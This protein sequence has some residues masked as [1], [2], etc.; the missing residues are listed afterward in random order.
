MA[1]FANPLLPRNGHTFVVG[2][3][4]R[5]SGC[6]NQKE[7]SLDDQ[8]DHGKQVAAE[9]DYGPAEYR[10][11]ATKGK[12]ERLDRPELAEIEALLRSG[13]LDLLV[14]EDIGRLV[15]GT[16]AARLCGLAVDHGTRVIAPNDCIDTAEDSWEEDVI[17]ACRDHVGHN[18]HTSKRLKHKLMNRFVKSGA[19]TPREIYGYIKPPGAKTY[20]D[21]QKD[22]AAT[23]IYQEWFERLRRLPNCS[24]VA[25]W[26]NAQQVPTGKYCRRK[27]WDGK[28][29]RRVTGN[30]LLKGMPGRGFRHTDKRHETG[31]RVSIPN[32][33]GP[34]FRQHP[35]LAHI[36]PDLWEEVNA[37]LDRANAGCGRKPVN[38]NDPRW[39]VPRKRTHF[40]GQ[41][42]RCWY[43]GRQCVWG[44]NGV[45]E[46]LMCNGAREWRCW[47]SLGFP[48]ALAGRRLREAITAELYRLEGF[49]AQFR[50]LVEQACQEGGA[51]LAQQGDELRRREEAL[52]RKQ[53]NLLDAIT[54]Y[55]P[56]P[57]FQQK[58]TELEAEVKQLQRE[59]QA[60]E[61]RNPRPLELPR[62]VGDLRH[63]LEE[64]FEEQTQ[65]SPEFGD[66]LRQ[67]VPEFFVYLVR[68]CDGGHLLPR[69][70]VKLSLGAL[71]PDTKNAPEIERLLSREL[72]LNLFEPPQRERIRPEAVRLAAQGLGQREIT[73]RLAETATQ[74]AVY[75]A[76][77]LERQMREQVLDTPYLLV[78][79]VPPDYTK[80]RRQQNRKYRFEAAEGY[81]RPAL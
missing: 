20:S 60:L 53:A 63:L 32:P 79:E 52:Q 73:H 68:L 51:H 55:G 56:K 61:R 37:L 41:H 38:G 25:D 70:R 28:M 30:S 57:M 58:L 10:V 81:Q 26:L 76:L 9:Y 69:A 43:C 5:I 80:L 44:G 50:Q 71:I 45:T 2:I 7:L 19:A 24:A 35:E 12:G 78:T 49:D 67:L 46:N 74:A 17:S 16:E 21:W 62:S 15:R 64:Q 65:D 75:R 11:I 13:E 72:T 39:R 18:A 29:V 33:K 36:D 27:T 47:N 23:P 59:R 6:P 1:E 22:P 31:R 54:N 8:T 48:G 34:K 4:A 3:I 77:A 14:V 42:A 40:P 66:L